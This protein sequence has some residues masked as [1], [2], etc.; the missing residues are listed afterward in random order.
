MHRLYINTVLH[1]QVLVCVAILKSIHCSK[2]W[3]LRDY[4]VLKCWEWQRGM[5]GAK[6]MKTCWIWR[7]LIGNRVIWAVK[8]KSKTS[9]AKNFTIL[10]SYFNLNEQSDY[11]FPCILVLTRHFVFSDWI[12]V[13]GVD[14][15]SL[16]LLLLLEDTY[17][18]TTFLHH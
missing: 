18:T 17:I 14:Y 6:N 12:M 1:P 10:Y 8:V 5:I 2:G 11:G 3:M 9:M 4:C 13:D 7:W 15:H 16:I